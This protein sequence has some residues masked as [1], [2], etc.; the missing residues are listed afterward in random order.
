MTFRL[1]E[2]FLLFRTF[3]KKYFRVSLDRQSRIR[4]GKARKDKSLENLYWLS[5]DTADVFGGEEGKTLTL[6]RP[7]NDWDESAVRVYLCKNELAEEPV[8]EEPTTEGI[9]EDELTRKEAYF[10][11][12]MY[13]VDIIPMLGTEPKDLHQTKEE[14]YPKVTCGFAAKKVF[15][16]LCGQ[17]PVG[18]ELDGSKF[19]KFCKGLPDV[20]DGKKIKTTDIDILFAKSKQKDQR[21][22]KFSEFFNQ[23]LVGLAEK[24]LVYFFGGGGGGGGLP[25]W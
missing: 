7:Y 11:Y 3:F 8:V 10:G 24:R 23:A 20:V 1:I 17:K 15:Q 21:R 19:T 14:W 16:Y 2:I 13:W 25:L 5:V 9:R 18:K 6:R 12:Q 22:L 4:L